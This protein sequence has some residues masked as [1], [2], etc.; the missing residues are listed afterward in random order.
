MAAALTANPAAIAAVGMDVSVPMPENYLFTGAA[1]YKIPIE[2]PPGRGGIA[3]NIALQ[4]NSYQR[5]SW[6]GIGFSLEMGA[7]QRSTKYGVSYTPADPGGDYV[8]V[9]NGSTTE[10]VPRTDWCSTCFGAK[11]E[12]DFS[13]FYYN[14]STQGWEVTTKDGT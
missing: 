13:K 12:K 14:S 2:V 9:I 4:Y 6:V 11:I 5:N 10:L 1:T 3:P 8:A 7:I